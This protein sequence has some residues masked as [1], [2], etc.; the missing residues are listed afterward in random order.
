MPV[1]GLRLEQ[2]WRQPKITPD[3]R[4][5]VDERAMWG[6]VVLCT[7]SPL[8][9]RVEPYTHPQLQQSV[10]QRRRPTGSCASDDELH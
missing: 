2:G 8:L 4:R 10:P 1:L 6:P 3:Q 7:P 9:Q 5:E